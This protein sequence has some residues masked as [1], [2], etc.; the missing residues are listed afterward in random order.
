M[1]QQLFEYMLEEHGI[2]LLQSDMIEI[3]RIVLEKIKE[4]EKEG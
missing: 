2:T 1:N 3:E 4:E